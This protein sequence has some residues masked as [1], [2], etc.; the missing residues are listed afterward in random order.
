MQLRVYID[1]VPEDQQ[2]AEKL[3][4]LLVEKKVIKNTFPTP[5]ADFEKHY[6]YYIPSE[7]TTLNRLLIQTAGCVI[8]ISSANSGDGVSFDEDVAIAKEIGV[9]VFPVLVGDFNG[10]KAFLEHL[11]LDS[12]VKGDSFEEQAETLATD[13]VPDTLAFKNC[14]LSRNYDGKKLVLH[15]DDRDLERYLIGTFSMARFKDRPNFIMASSGEEALEIL[16]HVKPDLIILDIMMPGIGGVETL[17]RIKSNPKTRDLNVIMYSAVNGEEETEA[18]ELG[19]RA[20]VKKPA[21]ESL[22]SEM[23]KV[24]ENET[25]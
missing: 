2:Y 13:L 3:L 6:K 14:Y 23:K 20:Y 19:A 15:V 11:V 5:D 25:H 18:I 22:I 21:F 24:L 8:L 9:P 16:E 10:K 7:N 12:Y 4:D 17:R 1:F